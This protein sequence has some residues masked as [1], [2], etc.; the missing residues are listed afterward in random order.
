MLPGNKPIGSGRLSSS[1]PA[2]GAIAAQVA[3][4]ETATRPLGR[5]NELAPHEVA[6]TGYPDYQNGRAVG[7]G[8]GADRVAGRNVR[9]GRLGITRDFGAAG[10]VGV[11]EALRY[12]VRGM[13]VP[14]AAVAR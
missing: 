13:L 3:P 12:I 14:I 4:S 2:L 11:D 5:D 7:S 1:T 8:P 6:G 10:G 9:F